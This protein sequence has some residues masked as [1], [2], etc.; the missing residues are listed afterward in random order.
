MLDLNTII[1]QALTTIVTNAVNEQTKPLVE[2]ITALESQADEDMARIAVLEERVGNRDALLR[3]LTTRATDTPAPSITDYL[4]L[5][6]VKSIVAKEVHDAIEAHLE[7]APHMCA[8]D[9]EEIVDDKI[10]DHCNSDY[11]HDSFL[12]EIDEDAVRDAVRD[13][14]EDAR[15]SISIR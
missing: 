1:T 14:L 4:K 11:D 9:V 10:S 5:E 3:D 8:D 2:R 13:C 15:V 7:N 6:D 12:T